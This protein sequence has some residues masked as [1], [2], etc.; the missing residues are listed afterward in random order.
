MMERPASVNSGSLHEWD[1]KQDP[2]VVSIPP[3]S[4]KVLLDRERWGGAKL[5]RGV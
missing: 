2:V 5:V 3:N 1:K 4:E